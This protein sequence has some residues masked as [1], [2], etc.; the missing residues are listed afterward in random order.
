M[1]KILLFCL[2]LILVFS[3]NAT[4]KVL[5]TNQLS[6]TISEV[7]LDQSVLSMDNHVAQ[8]GSTGNHM[9]EADGKIYVVCSGDNQVQIFDKEDYSFVSAVNVGAGTNPW[10]VGVY[11]EKIWVTCWLTGEVKV[12]DLNGELLQT[13]AVG[14]GPEGLCMIDGYVWI[15]NSGFVSYGVFENTSLMKIN[16][17]SYEVESTISLT[18]DNCQDV[19]CLGGKLHAMCTSNYSNEGKVFIINPETGEID[20][21]IAIAGNP[22]NISAGNNA[23]YL[24]EGNWGS[25]GIYAYDRT[26][27]SLLEVSDELFALSSDDIAVDNDGNI[28]VSDADDWV[29]NG[30]VYVF[31]SAG[32]LIGSVE[33]GIG[34]SGLLVI[35]NQN[36]VADIALNSKYTKAFPNP[37]NPNVTISLEKNYIGNYKVEIFNILGKK[38]AENIGMASGEIAYTWNGKTASGH[39]VNTGIYFYKIKTD[40]EVFS[41]RFTILK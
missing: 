10:N 24:T 36:G 37:A 9:I 5:V 34:A 11:D 16:M 3:A 27:Y 40:N 1:K 29:N 30:V 32:A 38:I 39:N 19:I 41:G 26:D 22:T 14:N 13:I 28:F 33:A 25:T 35:Q 2:S 31:D 6:S 17:S 4:T 21:E 7:T 20:H 12:F 8:I 15:A 23:V 18:T